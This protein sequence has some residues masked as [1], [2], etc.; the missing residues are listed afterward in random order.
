MWVVVVKLYKQI[1][2]TTIIE[3]TI[4]RS[5]RELLCVRINFSTSCAAA[6]SPTTRAT[7]NVELVCRVVSCGLLNKCLHSEPPGVRGHGTTV[8]RCNMP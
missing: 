4:C 6:G 1:K 8:L 2:W 7:V 3:T 5:L